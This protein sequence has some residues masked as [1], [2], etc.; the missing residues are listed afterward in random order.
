MADDPSDG[1]RVIVA[2]VITVVG[3]IG[4]ATIVALLQ[5]LGESG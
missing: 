1:V 4:I 5:W 2:L 3:I